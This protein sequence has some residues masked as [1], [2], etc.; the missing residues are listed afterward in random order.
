MRDRL[1]SRRVIAATGRGPGVFTYNLSGTQFGGSA[2]EG[3]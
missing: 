2:V 1:A 3:L